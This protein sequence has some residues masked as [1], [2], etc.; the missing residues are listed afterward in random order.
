MLRLASDSDS[1][2]VCSLKG[3]MVTSGSASWPFVLQMTSLLALML[4]PSG[5]GPG[6]FGKFNWGA[7]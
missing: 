3:F 2:K 6:L 7:V 1:S 5:E 4:R